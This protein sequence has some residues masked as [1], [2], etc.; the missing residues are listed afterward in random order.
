M[1]ETTSV[2]RRLKCVGDPFQGPWWLCGVICQGRVILEKN[3][4]PAR[5]PANSRPEWG[6]TPRG[7]IHQNE[8]QALVKKM[9]FSKSQEKV[10]TNRAN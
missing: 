8:I 2:V 4:A 10:Q 3:K 5:K 9:S 7:S 6:S 1:L